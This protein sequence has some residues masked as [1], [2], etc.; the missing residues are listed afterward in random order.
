MRS[1]PFRLFRTV[2]ASALI[3]V[4]VPQSYAQAPEHLVSPS[5]LQ[6]AA[7]GASEQRQK[8]VETL[9]SFLSSDKARE[10]I[11]SAHMN[12]DQVTRAVGGLSDDELAQ[13]TARAHQAQSN[14]SAGVITDRDL[15]VILIALAVVILIVAAVN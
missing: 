13:L 14:F 12:P 9:R 8:N 2:A 5:E 4:A 1:E 6:K 7:V 11:R 3:A 10:A 15:L